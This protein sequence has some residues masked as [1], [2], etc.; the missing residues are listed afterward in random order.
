[1]GIK[2]IKLDNKNKLVVLAFALVV[3]VVLCITTAYLGANKNSNT[4]KIADAVAKFDS[5]NKDGGIKILE[6]LLKKDPN[7]NDLK[8]KLA[9]YY[10]QA[11]KLDQFVSYVE[12][13][14]LKSSAISNMLA[15]I[16][17]DKAD[18]PKAEDYYREAIAQAPNSA[19]AYVN[20]AA[21]YQAHGHLDQALVTIKQGISANPKSTL[22]LITASS[23]C[24]K[25]SDKVASASYANQ[26]LALDPDNSQAKSILSNN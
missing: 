2:N 5:G 6:D 12:A 8:I 25:M 9:S 15:T 11:D 13:E 26:V 20:F 23:I 16:Y 1:M 19:R 17:Q 14:Q 3:I 10:Y 22:L 24:Y 21:Y 18:Y 4:T 7:N